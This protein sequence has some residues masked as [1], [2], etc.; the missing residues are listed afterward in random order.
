VRVA[1]TGA[2]LLLGLEAGL[3][4]FH[5]LAGEPC[6][7]W[8][9]A[10][11]PRAELSEA[12]WGALPGPPIPRAP[13]GTPVR[14]A[15]VGGD[16][17]LVAGEDIEIAWSDLAHRLE[18]AAIVRVLALA[19]LPEHASAFDKLWTWEHPLAKLEALGEAPDP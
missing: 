12:E 11:E 6:H 15:V 14:D 18:E 8:V 2:D 16:R 13:R 10:L 7:V 4:R 17:T 19:G 1:G 3:H 5:G 9:D